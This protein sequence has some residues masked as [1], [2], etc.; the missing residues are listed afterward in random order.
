MD[1]KEISLAGLALIGTAGLGLIG[2]EIVD[3][4]RH[5]RL[6]KIEYPQPKVQG[7][8][9]RAYSRPIKSSIENFLESSVV[10]S[11]YG[12]VTDFFAG[13]EDLLEVIFSNYA[14][15]RYT[16]ESTLI[17]DTNEV[18]EMAFK[19]KTATITERQELI[20]RKK[21][22]RH[23]ITINYTRN[24]DF[25][26]PSQNT[27]VLEL[28]EGDSHHTSITGS[29]IRVQGSQEEK[30]CR[31]ELRKDDTDSKRYVM[32]YFQNKKTGS[33]QNQESTWEKMPFLHK[34]RE[35][36]AYWLKAS[37]AISSSFADYV[38]DKKVEK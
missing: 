24:N 33:N 13:S 7:I 26:E 34:Q 14:Q 22:P 27:L 37:T 3:T 25:Y 32:D 5:P 12:D 15:W 17:T 31:W 16:S 28:M 20:E 8:F 19:Q 23:T 29:L 11:E 1:K 9:Q 4:F 18:K 38:V 30:R 6:I 10:N 35:L 2:Y 21:I 36:P